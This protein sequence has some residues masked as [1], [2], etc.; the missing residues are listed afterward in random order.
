M[1]N[2]EELTKVKIKLYFAR[3]MTISTIANRL[4]RPRSYVVN[5]LGITSISNRAGF[6]FSDIPASDKPN[7]ANE[8]CELGYTRSET[9]RMLGV[10]DNVVSKWITDKRF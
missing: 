8:L 6:A 5:V 2:N 3:G 10:T 4:N 1:T 7:K 9:A